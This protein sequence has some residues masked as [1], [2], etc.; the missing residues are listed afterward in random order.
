MSFEQEPRKTAPEELSSY[1]QEGVRNFIS[2][3]FEESYN[4]LK[5]R[6][7]GGVLA[8]WDLATDSKPRV[9]VYNTKNNTVL[10]PYVDLD[11]RFFGVF[12]D[13]IQIGTGLEVTA[14]DI[15]VD[16]EK[17]L[18]ELP[19]NLREYWGQN[20]IGIVFSYKLGGGKNGGRSI[21][22]ITYYSGSH[23]MNMIA[24]RWVLEEDNTDSIQDN[25]EFTDL[26]PKDPVKETLAGISDGTFVTA[27]IFNF[28]KN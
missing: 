18:D 20:L 12:A 7:C 25:L 5:N 19:S 2:E 13:D 4:F 8:Q 23:S 3:R 9:I 16:D 28:S 14:E 22:Q 17:E 27:V 6:H 24:E 26:K 10:V 15:S 21:K 1:F 11:Q